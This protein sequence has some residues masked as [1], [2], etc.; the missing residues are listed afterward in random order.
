MKQIVAEI[1]SNDEIIEVPIFLKAKHLANYVEKQETADYMSESS[2]FREYADIIAKAFIDSNP[3]ARKLDEKLVLEDLLEI[4]S[5]ISDD[6]DCGL[7]LVVDAID[8]IVELES[9]E[10]LL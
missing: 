1:S 8:E 4:N 3:L 6:D 7:V 9:I 2:D 10:I 5:N